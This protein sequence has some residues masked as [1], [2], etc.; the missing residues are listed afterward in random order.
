VAG[1]GP[2]QRPGARLQPARLLAEPGEKGI[3]RA[4]PVI[5]TLR[6]LR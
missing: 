6:S 3:G 5:L 1:Q 4:H 2:P